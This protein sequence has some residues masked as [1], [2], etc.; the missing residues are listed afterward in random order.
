MN[1]PI[2]RY[3]APEIK[4]VEL[5]LLSFYLDKMTTSGSKH[6]VMRRRRFPVAEVR[7]MTNDDRGGQVREETSYRSRRNVAVN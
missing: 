3:R 1:I 7:L 5:D 6:K 4:I 2:Y